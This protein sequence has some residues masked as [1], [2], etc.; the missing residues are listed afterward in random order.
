MQRSRTPRWALWPAV[1]REQSLLFIHWCRFLLVV[2]LYRWINRVD[3]ELLASLCTETLSTH[4]VTDAG[5]P[6]LNLDCV[7]IL[8]VQLLPGDSTT[9]DSV[10][11]VVG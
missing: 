1:A 11:L 6:V 4:D 9:K 8:S 3:G 10:K 2:A 5:E 7:T